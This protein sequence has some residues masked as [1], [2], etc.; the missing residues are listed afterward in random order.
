MRFNTDTALFDAFPMARDHIGT[1]PLDV[2]PAAFV[3][4]LTKASKLGEALS[5]C[6]YL[7][8]RREAVA[9]GCRCLRARLAEDA[10]PGASQGPA[11][12]AAEAWADAPSDKRRLRAYDCWTAGHREDPATWFALATA[13]SGGSMTPGVP[14]SPFAAPHLTAT[15]VRV[16]LLLA[17][18][19]V[20]AP[21]RPDAAKQWIGAGL[22]LAETGLK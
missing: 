5:F 17:L 13:W 12:A 16:G 15:L 21:Q 18:N 10:A 11:L 8:A 2:P 4:A 9:W 14:N 6:S 3:D 20:A 19:R 1:A 22:R 7:L